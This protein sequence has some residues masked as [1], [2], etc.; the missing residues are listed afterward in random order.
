MEKWK[1]CK[2]KTITTFAF[3]CRKILPP[4]IRITAL[5]SVFYFFIYLEFYIARTG[6][7]RVTECFTRIVTEGMLKKGR[8]YTKVQYKT[9]KQMVRN[10]LTTSCQ[11]GRGRMVLSVK[12]ICL[13]VEFLTSF[14]KMEV[15]VLHLISDG[16]EFQILVAIPEKDRPDYCPLRGMKLWQHLT[17]GGQGFLSNNGQWNAGLIP[18]INAASWSAEEHPAFHSLMSY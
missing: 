1:K 8:Q 10:K 14:L 6:P 12:E 15:E 7:F 2:E 17:L 16:R 18:D 5:L 9:N 11:S 13:Q 3:T 4:G